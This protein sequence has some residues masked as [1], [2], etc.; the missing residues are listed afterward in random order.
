[1]LEP[2][3]ASE[4]LESMKEYIE[5]SIRREISIL[6]LNYFFLQG[7][8][9]DLIGELIFSAASLQYASKQPVFL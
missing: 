4:P 7:V 1:L 2:G 5:S 6:K 9:D 8:A 3:G